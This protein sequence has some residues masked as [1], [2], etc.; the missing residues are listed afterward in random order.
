V[1]SARENDEWSR[2]FGCACRDVL[3]PGVHNVTPKQPSASEERQNDFGLV[4][5]RDELRAPGRLFEQK[6]ALRSRWCRPSR[7]VDRTR[8]PAVVS[9]KREYFKYLPETIGY[10]TPAVAKFGTRRRSTESQKPAISGRFWPFLG[11]VS[12]RRTGWLGR[13]DTHP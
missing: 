6:P 13:E 12:R 5:A 3:A 2:S 9:R 10:L 4:D 8:S 7:S 1:A 11:K